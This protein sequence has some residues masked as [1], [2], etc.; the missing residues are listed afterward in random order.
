LPFHFL[1]SPLN[2]ESNTNH[3]MEHNELLFSHPPCDVFYNSGLKA[4]ETR[5]K[6]PAAEGLLLHTIL[7]SIIEALKQKTS[8][9][10]IADARQMQVITRDDI[11]WVS[12]NWYP[13]ALAA[14]FR[15]EALVV[16][17]YTFNSVTVRKIVST[18][19]EQKLKTAYFKTLPAAYAWVQNGFP[20]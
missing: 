1:F 7:D 13:R 9:V 19:D 11:Q 10:V 12:G 5:W 18:Y 17:D 4:V 16:T 14:G 20:D 2:P 6:G 3:P 15:Y 8:S